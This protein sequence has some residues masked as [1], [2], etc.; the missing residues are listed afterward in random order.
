VTITSR[1]IV[2]IP[3]S[4]LFL[5]VFFVSFGRAQDTGGNSGVTAVGSNSLRVGAGT[6]DNGAEETMKRYF[7]EI[8]NAHLFFQNFSVGLRY[9]MDDP[10][11]VG[12]SFQGIRRRWINYNKDKLELQAGDVSAL[13]G[14]GAAIN[15]F[16]SRPLNYDSWLDG[17]S[18][19]YE[20]QWKKQ[21]SDLQPSFG[22]HGVEGKLNY[23]DIDSTKPVM[24]VSARAIN[25]EFG[26]FKKQLVFGTSFVQAFTSVNDKAPGNKTTETDREVNQPE[27]YMSLHA[28]KFDFFG[29]Y[30]ANHETLS[31]V[32][33]QVD[34]AHNDGTAGYFAVSY[35]S[36]DI[37]IT[38][39]YKN[40]SYFVAP[41]NSVYGEYFG[42][43]PISSPPEVYK[44]FT[45]TSIT[46]TT[47]A[48]NF[49]D[50][51]GYQLEFNITAIPNTTIN[52]DGAASS[53]HKAYGNVLDSNGVANTVGSTS[54]LPKLN[55]LAYYPF[56]E[57]FVEVEYELSDLNFVKVFWHR[58]SDEIVYNP[59]DP[60]LSDRKSSTTIGAKVQY[61]TTPNQSILAIFEH[62]WMTDYARLIPDKNFLNE[63]LTLQYSFNPL[64]NFGGVFDFST[65]YEEPRHIW[66][67]AFVSV[68]IG[69]SHNLIVSYGMERGG[70]N[71]TGG[72]C[73]VVPAFNGMRIGLTSQL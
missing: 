30:T 42:K 1:F 45:Y 51:V 72:I 47:H 65:E 40:Y 29:E 58:R 19:S 41:T 67:E 50:E 52:V 2:A 11:E 26:L 24:A 33:D 61:E 15:L 3:A 8:A 62:Q 20:Y 70:L 7:E 57:G 36:P 59:N 71:C 25:G 54:I 53:R 46:R 68:R 35:A 16:E 55:D 66:P 39:D 38:F 22:V 14:R 27:G 32:R 17:L 73:R 9:E 5:S 60:S 23:I 6:T 48:V 28:G 13:Y 21:Q 44:D 4:I 49:N 37:G 43:L 31:K 64:L 18:G 63:L 10:S 69:E 12:P 34:S 56:Y